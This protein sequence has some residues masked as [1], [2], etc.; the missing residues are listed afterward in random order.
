[1]AVSSSGEIMSKERMDA[2][3]N[4]VGPIH[5]CPELFH[6]KLLKPIDESIHFKSQTQNGGVDPALTHHQ[7]HEEHPPE[8]DRGARGRG[9]G[10]AA[11]PPGEEGGHGGED[12][13]HNANGKKICGVRLSSPSNLIL[14]IFLLMYSSIYSHTVVSHEWLLVVP[15]NL[16]LFCLARARNIFSNRCISQSF[17][18]GQVLF[19]CSVLL[20][21]NDLFL[22]IFACTMNHFTKEENY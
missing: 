4:S 9:A 2:I 1:M 11:G 10:S 13:Q 3:R 12:G 14:L 7:E 16:Y 5:N 17:R 8:P 6:F 19:P 21:L 18:I 20:F 22:V 15:T